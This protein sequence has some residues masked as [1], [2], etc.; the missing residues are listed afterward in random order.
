VEKLVQEEGVQFFPVPMA[1]EISP[2]QDLR[3]LIRIFFLLRRLRPAATNFSTP[4]AGLLGTIAAALARVPCRI[5][6]L[7]GLRLE[8][9]AGIKR[10]LLWVSEWLACRSSHVTVCISE[11]LRKQAAHLGLVEASRTRV[12]G[13]GSS[14][15]IDAAHFARTSPGAVDGLKSALGI[16]P[17]APVIGFVGRL[18]R[19]KGIPE[20][21]DAFRQ[22]SPS[23][24]ELRLLLVGDFE[25]GDPVPGEVRRY[26]EAEPRIVHAGFV[27]NVAPYYAIM[28][29]FA[30]PTHRE[31]FGGASLEA[32]ASGVPVVASRATG[33]VDSVIDNETGL[34][35]PVGDANALSAG[36]CRLLDDPEL[37]RRMGAAGKARA[38]KEFAPEIIWR[39]LADLYGEL[40]GTR[41]TPHSP[42]SGAIPSEAC[43]SVS[44]ITHTLAS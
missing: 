37:R 31:G 42:F 12:F 13:N 20:L 35:V 18:V 8:T 10:R 33:V 39:G 40:I 26:I 9:A 28:D 24:P 11:S 23:R 16:P 1:R 32:Q 4:K 21:V 29:V 15:G 2:F 3:S 34:L 38:R 44:S 43:E 41:P 25:E 30:F 17:N 27:S 36:I 19:D 22:L 7:R 14:N 5:Y 6:T